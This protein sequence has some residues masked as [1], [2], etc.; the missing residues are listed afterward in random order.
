VVDFNWLTGILGALA[1]IIAVLVGW[2]GA[3]LIGRVAGYK[4][5]VVF[6]FCFTFAWLVYMFGTWG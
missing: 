3:A 4:V 2:Y 1:A 5:L 6:T